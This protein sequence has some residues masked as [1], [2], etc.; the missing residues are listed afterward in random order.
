MQNA[1]N[2]AAQKER[3]KSTN[4]RNA[5]EA[6]ARIEALHGKTNKPQEGYLD[7]QGHIEAPRRASI[8]LQPEPEKYPAGDGRRGMSEDLIIRMG[9]DPDPTKPAVPPTQPAA[10]KTK[11]QL[12]KEK[13]EAT[14]RMNAYFAKNYR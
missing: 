6:K 11:E 1:T 10:P 8:V 4:E 7:A 14:E 2:A 13:L 5:A 12:A 3:D 9:M